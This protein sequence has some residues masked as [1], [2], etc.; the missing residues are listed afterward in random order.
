MSVQKKVIGELEKCYSLALLG[1]QGKKHFLAASEKVNQCR[2]YDLEGNLEEVLWEQPGG[3]MTMVPV[4]G[5]DGQILATQR[6]YSPNDSKEASIISAVPEEDGWKIRTLAKLPFI[7]RFDIL[8]SGSRKYLIACT[9]KSGHEYK[10]D[11]SEPGKV[12]GALLPDDVTVFDDDHPLQLEV[13]RENMLRNHGYFKRVKDGRE[14]AVIACEQGVFRFV[15]PSDRQADWEV[16]QLLSL[17]VSDALM[18]DLDGCGEEELL[19]FSPFHGDTISIF[20]IMDGSYCK[21]YEHPE[22]L[23]FLHAICCG[24]LEGMPAAFVGFR[25]GEQELLALMSDGRGGF[26]HQVLDRGCGP[27]NVVYF[28]KEGK[29]FLI[30]AN[31][32]IDE[33]AMY[34]L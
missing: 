28:K 31:R 20:K 11:W 15:P 3:V 10:D 13:I 6:F 24:Y 16:E 19:V 9:L 5:T 26:K 1:Y 27:A 2:M 29:D 18:M 33:I 21:V 25:K 4:P 34:T 17:P 23:E 14:E 22:K 12:Y 8:Q 32:E 30:A 7:H